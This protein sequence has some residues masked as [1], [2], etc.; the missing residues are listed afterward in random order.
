MIDPMQSQPGPSKSTVPDVSPANRLGLDYRAEAA[1]FAARP[2]PIIDVHTHVLGGQ[3]ARIYRDA[4]ETYGIG[5]T[6]S[7]TPLELVPPVQDV[8]DDAIRFIAVPNWRAEDK[9]HEFGKQF[10]RTIEQFHA[11]G[12]RICKFWVAPRSVDVAEELGDRNFLKLNSPSKIAA[13]EAASEL[14]MYFMTHVADPDTWFATKYADA[15]RYGTKR[16]QYEPLEELLERFDQPWIAAH[17][18]GWPEDL[19]FLTGLLERHPN[20]HLDTSACKWMVR[21]L[22]KHSREQFIA[23]L[24]RFKGRILFGSDIVTAD[25]HLHPSDPEENPMYAKANS[26][27]DAF[28]LYASR[29][30]AFRTLFETDYSGESPIADPDLNMIDPDRYTVLDAPPLRGKQVPEELLQSMYHDTAHELLEPLHKA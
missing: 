9:K 17:M 24:Q 21:E 1:K 3:A 7:M 14:G 13:M 26:P 11:R 22:S 5:L 15:S 19:E 20:L 28:D 27:E 16:Q 10:I 12:S 8:M 30:W 6:Y 2:T 25:E 23:F 4:A 29:F 18:G